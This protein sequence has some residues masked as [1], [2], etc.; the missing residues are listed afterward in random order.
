MTWV[1]VSRGLGDVGEHVLGT[2]LGT[3]LNGL[4]DWQA[5]EWQ[6]KV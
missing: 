1:E 4:L 6:L 5:D 3:C 2:A